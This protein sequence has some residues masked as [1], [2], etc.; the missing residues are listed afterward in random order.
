MSSCFW[1]GERF[2]VGDMKDVDHLIDEGAGLGV[3]DYLSEVEES[4]G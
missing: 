4:I 2:V 1:V 3:A